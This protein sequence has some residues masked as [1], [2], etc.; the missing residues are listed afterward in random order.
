MND[1]EIVYPLHGDGLRQRSIRGAAITSVS[2]AAK[3]LLLLASQIV[4]ARLL[5]PADF[6]IIAMIAPISGFVTVM[7]DLGITQA[8]VQRPSLTRGQLNSVF[9]VN[10][11]LSVSMALILMLLAP[12]LAWFY[13]EPR[14]TAVA[15]AVAILVVFTGLSMQQTALLNRTM[16]FLPLA[17]SDI[18]SLTMALLASALA[19]WRGLG[20][21]SLIIGLAATTVTVNLVVWTASNWRPSLPA[22]KADAFSMLRFGG[23]VTVSNIALY[24]NSVIDNAL[25]GRYLGTVPLGLYDRAWK[26]AVMPLSQLMAPVNRVAVPT[27]ARLVDDADRY[28]NH[29]AKCSECFFWPACRRW[30]SAS[31]QRSP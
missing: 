7:A 23:N 24:L 31:W 16:R 22:I 15:I 3:L 21:W 13:H 12:G 30:P 28:R 25:V 18:L 14:L 5:Y 4:L 6:G 9:W 8:I 27:L 29:S 26:L 17:V 1:A 10:V 19:A 2:Q 20:Y 11:L